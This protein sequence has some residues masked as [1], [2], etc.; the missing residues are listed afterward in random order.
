MIASLPLKANTEKYRI[1]HDETIG[2]TAW[3]LQLLLAIG[4]DG[5]AILSLRNN[6]RPVNHSPHPTNVNF[7]FL[8]STYIRYAKQKVVNHL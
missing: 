2:N 1:D 5:I 3:L 4:N 6:S 8:E 7:G